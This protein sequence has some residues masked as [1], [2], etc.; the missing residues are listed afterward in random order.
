MI[1]QR[2]ARDRYQTT[3]DPDEGDSER[4]WRRERAGYP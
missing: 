3:K 2:R 4:L 1:D